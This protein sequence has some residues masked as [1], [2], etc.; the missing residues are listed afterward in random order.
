MARCDR[1]LR[2]AGIL[3]DGFN[4]PQTLGNLMHC[5]DR[6]LARFAALLLVLAATS[7][8]GGAQS[9]VDLAKVPTEWRSVGRAPTLVTESGRP[10]LRVDEA[11]GS[12]M[13]WT[14]NPPFTDGEI[15]LNVRG[16]NVVQKSFVGIAFHVQDDSTFDVVWLRP[17]NFRATEAAKRGHSVQFAS[18]PA[19]PWQRLRAEHP[20]AFEAEVPESVDPDGWV[21]VRVTVHGVEVRVFL[22]GSAQP[23]LTILSP[24]RREN[25]GGIGLFVGDNSN[26]AFADLHVRR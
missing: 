6:T 21:H 24:S 19:F 11:A 2:R 23:V 20:G 16:R 10:V 8:V 1:E 22:N 26:G 15:E 12:G 9:S 17:F 3:T 18:Y 4:L 25:R 5:A 7:T 13:V 14:P